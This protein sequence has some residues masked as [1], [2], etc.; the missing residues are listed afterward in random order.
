MR[1]FKT[2]F[3]CICVSLLLSQQHNSVLYKSYYEKAIAIYEDDDPDAASELKAIQY[4]DTVITLLQ[5]QPQHKNHLLDSYVKAGNIYQGQKKYKEAMPY[6]HKGLQLSTLTKDSLFIYQFQLYMGAAKYSLNEIDSARYLFEQA[7]IITASV[8]DLPDLTILYNS[9]G[10]IYYES[11]NYRRAIDYFEKAVNGLDKY[12]E[13]YDEAYVSFKNNIAGCYL[14]LKEF[15]LA[16]DEYLKLLRYEQITEGLLQNIGHT[17][18]NLKLYDSCL[19]YLNKIQP[20]ETLTYARLL[21]E[22]ARVFMNKNFLPQAEVVFD[23]AIHLIRRLPGYYKNK[24]KANSYLYRSQLAE[25]QQLYNEAVSWCNIALQELHFT[26]K[27]TRA[28]DLPATFTEVIS[29]VTFFEVL[30]QKAQLLYQQ[31]LETGTIQS[32]EAALQTWLL[33]VKTANYI[34]SDFDNDEA[35]LFFNSN[36]SK[37]YQTAAALAARLFERTGAAVHMNAFLLITESFKGNVLYMNLNR[38]NAKSSGTIPDSLVKKEY[39][40]KQLLAVFTNRLNTTVSEEGAKII[41]AKLTDIRFQLSRLH[42]QFEA[43]PDYSDAAKIYNDSLQITDVQQ[44]LANG[45]AV[46]QMLWLDTAVVLFT[47]SKDNYSLQYVQ[48]DSSVLNAIR[49]STQSLY[50]TKEGLRFAGYEPLHTVYTFLTETL[51]RDF[52]DHKHW[53]VLPDGPF[54]YLPF[55]SLVTDKN[56]RNYIAATKII[57]YHYSLSAM[58]SGRTVKHD[59]DNTFAA[60]PFH[61]EAVVANK[62]NFQTLPYSDTEIEVWSGKKMKGAQATKQTFLQQGAPAH[63]IHLATHAIAKT[64]SLKTDQTYIQF[65]PVAANNPDQSRLYLHELYSMKFPNQPLVIL[66][67]C[68][69]AAGTDGGG[70]GLLS[71][72][73]AFLY[74]GCNGIISSLWKAEDKT[75]AYIIQRTHYYLKNGFSVEEALH[76]GRKD[77]LMDETIDARFKT[78]DY[79]AHLIYIGAVDSGESMFKSSSDGSKW[80]YTL[81]ILL[82]MAGLHW[83]VYKYLSV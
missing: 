40:L 16:L 12:D 58:F 59:L 7:S 38:N 42:R 69:T 1:L 56:T 76:R 31:Y 51:P 11:A 79:W 66:S 33:A 9:L 72:S 18:Y 71:L 28:T 13:T 52:T 25:K 34:K 60:A 20:S 61:K 26:F 50:Q 10:I 29:P 5:N 80:A 8:T 68:E 15:R 43:Y 47:A 22:K 82:A 54:N 65:F 73:R 2:A 21:N 30:R 67:A 23:S 78:P 63:I 81:F 77:F 45:K 4:F 83:Y 36:Y 49:L 35:S 75:T 39:D 46:L 55:E 74:S 53:V 41:Q 70:E 44:K 24:D 37:D 3:L 48:P 14:K 64:D 19:F 32:G 6:Y 62:N 57:T 17:Y 27:A